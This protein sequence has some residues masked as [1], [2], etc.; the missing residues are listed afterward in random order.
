VKT[1]LFGTPPFLTTAVVPPANRKDHGTQ[2]HARDDTAMATDG[3]KGYRPGRDSLGTGERLVRH[4]H[5]KDRL[6]PTAAQEG[7]AAAHVARHKEARILR[8]APFRTP[9]HLHTRE[10]AGDLS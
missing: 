4:G 10:W 2:T 5:D 7:A 8:C 3:R 6:C 1:E 9:V